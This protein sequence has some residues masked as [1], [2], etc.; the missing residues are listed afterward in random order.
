MKDKKEISTEIYNS[1]PTHFKVLLDEVEKIVTNE[2]EQ[3]TKNHVGD[4]SYERRINMLKVSDTI[5]DKAIEKLKSMKGNFQG[6]NKAQSWLD[7]FLKIP[8]GVY[9]KE[10][11]IDFFKLYQEKIETYI[12]I[13]TIKLS[14]FEIEKLNE[15][16]NEIYNL[17]TQIVDEYHSI[18]FKS[19]NSYTVFLDFVM[20]IKE[21]IKNKL[22]INNELISNNDDIGYNMD[23]MNDVNM[24][25][26]KNDDSSI[27]IILFYNKIINDVIDNKS[28]NIIEKSIIDIEKFKNQIDG[29][30]KTENNE[31]YKSLLNDL[32][33]ILKVSLLKSDDE[34]DDDL[35]LSTVEYNHI[36]T[37]F[38]VLLH[39]YLTF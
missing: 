19:E 1:L 7:G 21:N 11:I 5:K 32:E 10:P 35:S 24:N 14:E 31:E 13:F 2:E 6:D 33:N 26:I 23:D 29:F 4:L 30:K 8:Y 17:I 37:K 38:K 16:N 15:R 34:E 22:L 3:L 27:K 9:K 20:N 36:F 12:N 28:V 39:K 25:N 18:I